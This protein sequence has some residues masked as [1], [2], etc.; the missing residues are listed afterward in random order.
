MVLWQPSRTH[1]A[2]GESRLLP[3][4]TPPEIRSLIA[5]R[6]LQL[7]SFWCHPCR[8]CFAATV[9]MDL[10]PPLLPFFFEPEV[11]EEPP[12]LQCSAAEAA[13]L[14]AVCRGDHDG[15]KAALKAG[16]SARVRIRRVDALKLL[17]SD[18]HLGS[19]WWGTQCSFPLLYMAGKWAS[20]EIC[21]LLLR[22]GASTADCTSLGVTALHM[23]AQEGR[24][25]VADALLRAG[26]VPHARDA[27]G[28]TALHY[29]ANHRWATWG[30]KPLD[31]HLDVVRLLLAPASD[32][33]SFARLPA[34][35]ALAVDEDGATAM[36]AAAQ[37]GST[38][39]CRA[40]YEHGVPASSPAGEYSA[41]HV[42]ASHGRTEVLAQ[43]LDWAPESLRAL[44]DRGEPPIC[45]AASH[46]AV[47]ALLLLV[48]RGAGLG[49]P[50]G[51][52]RAAARSGSVP[53]LVACLTL[54]CRRGLGP[55]CAA[56]RQLARS[57]PPPHAPPSV[58]AAHA[59]RRQ[60]AH[61]CLKL[62]LAAEQVPIRWSPAAHGQHPRHFRTRVHAL[63]RAL[64]PAQ[65]LRSLPQHLR[66]RILFSAVAWE[67]QTLLWPP[68]DA[69]LWHLVEHVEQVRT[70]AALP[71][72][73][74]FQENDPY[75]LAEEEE[76]PLV[77]DPA[78]QELLDV[79]GW[80]SGEEEELLEAMAQ[81]EL[82]IGGGNA[83]D[84]GDEAALGGPPA[85]Q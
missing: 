1:A 63:L 2:G 53:A 36:H 50:R 70:Q 83:S 44:D 77:V 62:L 39:L 6:G 79:D 16:A 81:M 10:P 21:Y 24:A 35:L 59:A 43:L 27:A 30:C 84:E 7:A 64:H 58:E 74:P 8:P 15:C 14:L 32:E 31:G 61:V 78:M 72:C 18:A 65:H 5:V 82:E 22:A 76:A 68:L 66:D 9:L 73:E 41:V 54:G 80:I 48:Q 49:S 26:A 47:G 51:L 17:G 56:A 67:A 45:V 46:G 13:L 55:A 71:E 4:L 19:Q 11:P 20:S 12:A 23:A 69:Q 28:W 33:V 37:S 42:A 34:T 75:G 25:G 38:A 3:L 57:R 85:L 29:C 52:L 40:L 60:A